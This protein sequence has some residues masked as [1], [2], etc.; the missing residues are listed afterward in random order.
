VVKP[1]ECVPTF[2]SVAFVP[3]GE[4]KIVAV[5]SHDEKNEFFASKCMK[6]YQLPFTNTIQM[7]LVSKIKRNLI[8]LF[9]FLL[10]NG[11]SST[12]VSCKKIFYCMALQSC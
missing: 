6:A 2:T 10:V 8:K 12:Q 1:T 4:V 5:I 7:K 3:V 11:I 9:L